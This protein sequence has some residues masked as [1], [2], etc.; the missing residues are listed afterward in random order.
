MK[1]ASRAWRLIGTD[2]VGP[3]HKTTRENTYTLT[4]VDYYTK[5]CEAVAIPRKVA[6]SVVRA[7][8]EIY[9]RHGV[10][11]RVISHNGG[12]FKNEVMRQMNEMYDIQ[13]VFTRPYAPQ[14]NCG[15]ENINKQL[16]KQLTL[17]ISADSNN[18]DLHLNSAL[19][20]LRTRPHTTRRFPPH[21]LMYSIAYRHGFSD[22]MANDDA[23]VDNL[24]QMDA[25]EFDQTVYR[26]CEEMMR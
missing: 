22:D 14:T 16:Q 17:A 20:V 4:V 13:H 23:T 8:H 12:E 10:P 1:I 24:M 18:W 7:L 21:D 6:L 5:W 26:Q 9:S 25:E 15:I 19:P 11:N 2:L 3:L